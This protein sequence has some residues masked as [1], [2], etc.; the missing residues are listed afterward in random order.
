MTQYDPATWPLEWQDHLA[1]RIA[2]MGHDETMAETVIQ[3]VAIRDVWQVMQ[4][5]LGGEPCESR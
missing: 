3:A 2:I 5:H 4:K 1:E